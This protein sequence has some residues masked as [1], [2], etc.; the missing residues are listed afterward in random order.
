MNPGPAPRPPTDRPRLNLTPS[1]ANLPG[2]MS[3]TSL[4]S[5]AVRSMS[6]ASSMMS[7]KTS[8]SQGAFSDSNN[9]AYN[10]IIKE[11]WCKSKDVRFPYTVRNKWLVLLPPTLDFCKN[12]SRESSFALPLA[13]ITGVTRIEKNNF[14]LQIDYVPNPDFHSASPLREQPSKPIVVQLKDDNDL[15]D[16]LDTIYNHCPAISGVSNPT[17][18]NHR[19]HVGFDP[20]NGNFIGL[21]REW[22][23]LLTA[24]AITQDDVAKHPETVLEVLDFYSD[25]T[26]RAQNMD[27]YAALMPTPPGSNQQSKQLGYGNRGTTVTP[28]RPA[29]PASVDRQVSYSKQQQTRYG[30]NTPPR[31][32]NG[33]PVQGQVKPPGIDRGYEQQQNMPIRQQEPPSQAKL[34]MGGDMRR[35]MEDEARRIQEQKDQRERQRAQEE[36]QSRQ[37]LAAYNASI[38]QKKVPLAQQELGG[39]GS[40]IEPQ[41]RYNPTRVAPSAPG[42]ERARQPAQ[43]S[44]RQTSGQR[45]GVPSPS[46]QNGSISAI[47]RAPYAQVPSASREQSPSS[48]ANVRAPARPDL[49][50]RQPSS[51][52]RMPDSNEDRNQS[53]QSRGPAQAVQGNGVTQSSRLPGPVQ[54]VKPLNVSSKTANGTAAAQ[55]IKPPVADGIKQAEMALTAKSPAAET[56]Q[57]E[58]R[59]SSMSESEVMSKLK[60]IVT[61]YDPLASYVKQRKIGQGASGSV[62]IAKVLADATSPVGKMVYKKD[63]DQAR[64]AIKTMDLRHQ[65]RKELIVNEIIVMKESLHPNIVNYLDSFLIENDT[66]LWVIMEYMNGGALTDVIE[67]NQKI[68]ED[69]IA[70]ISRE[71][72]PIESFGDYRLLS[73]VR[74]VKDW[75]IYMPRISSIVILRV[76]MCY[77][78]HTAV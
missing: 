16:W 61:K 47:P 9:Q 65:Q 38:P 76:T 50:Q 22:E 60:K 45:Q 29:P 77:S 55:Y 39:Y 70:A 73:Y 72:S 36:E 34:T 21:P 40:S 24:S 6:G 26:K 54:P 33:T 13:H 5:P 64:V 37:D 53:P 1:I 44:L 74:L 68:S 4:Q 7:F 58:V 18:F 62:Y 28:P 8:Y 14:S 67:N 30:E 31:S 66:E 23:K 3:S 41:N 48:Q 52:S 43:G 42:V 78:I 59:M 15:Y 27:D 12:E 10:N 17:N 20:T 25:L 2:N 57:K 32:Q 46:A 56:R 19:V 63:G 35:A 75:H 71:V 11:G 69:Q 49:Q 51:T